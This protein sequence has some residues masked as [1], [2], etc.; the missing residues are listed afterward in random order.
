M[1]IDI[2]TVDAIESAQPSLTWFGHGRIAQ[3]WTIYRSK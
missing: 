3:A 1:T 2:M